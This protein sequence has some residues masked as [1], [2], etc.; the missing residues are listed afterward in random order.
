MSETVKV[1]IRCR[2]YN[3]KEKETQKQQIVKVDESRREIFIYNPKKDQRK[4]FTFDYT[5]GMQSE[6]KQ[7]FEDCAFGIIESVLEGYNGTIFAYG[8]TGTGKTFTMEGESSDEN[9]KGIIP[10]SFEQIFNTI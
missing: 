6:Q 7:I 10:R 4:Q 5:Y 9:L 2:P 8:Q 1:A 3:N